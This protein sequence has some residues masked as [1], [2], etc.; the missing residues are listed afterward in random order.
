MSTNYYLKRIPT[1]EE[2]KNCEACLKN[3]R[4][5]DI[6]SSIFNTDFKIGVDDSVSY[7]LNKMTESIHIGKTASGWKFLFRSHKDIYG[8]DLKSVFKFIN[9]SISSGLWK[10]ID[11]YGDDISFNDFKSLV[12][13]SMEDGI[14]IE[15]YYRRY[16]E[17]NYGWGGGPVQTISY[18]GSRW[19]DVDFI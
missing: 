3:L 2:L 9:K 7:W 19:W 13:D 11:E 16:P 10:L 6:S 18:D 14:D 8:E 12:K 15:E 17:R 1:E 5:E 4:L